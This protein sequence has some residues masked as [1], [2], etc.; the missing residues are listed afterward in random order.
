MVFVD[1]E[2]AYDR[3]PRELIWYSLSRKCVPEAYVNII[4]DMYAGCNTSVMNSAGNTKEI[5]IE[6]G[7]H[8]GSALSPLLFV[9]IIYV[10]TEKIEEGPSWAILFA[11]RH[12]VVRS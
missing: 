2:K 3:I 10:I 5:H 1:L 7:L 6:V 12:G 9:I 8:Q 4:R 11:G